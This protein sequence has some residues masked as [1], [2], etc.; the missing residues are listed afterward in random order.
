ML[1]QWNSVSTYMKALD[2]QA[3]EGPD[4]VA[5]SSQILLNS[6]TQVAHSHNA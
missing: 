3:Y 5:E 1:M 4:L 2:M 6:V